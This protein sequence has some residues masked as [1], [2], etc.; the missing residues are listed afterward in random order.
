MYSSL[1]V[2]VFGVL[3]SSLG[4]MLRVASGRIRKA[5]ALRDKLSNIEVWSSRRN[6][7][8]QLMQDIRYG[9]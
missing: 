4:D 9:W 5:V 8:Q 2:F 1:G 3:L 7:P 6:F